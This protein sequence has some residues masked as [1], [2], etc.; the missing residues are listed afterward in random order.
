MNPFSERLVRPWEECGCHG[1]VSLLWLMKHFELPRLVAIHKKIE[2]TTEALRGEG[3]AYE[4]AK[5]IA[6]DRLIALLT[7]I[8]EFCLGVEFRHAYQKAHAALVKIQKRPEAITGIEIATILL[9]LQDDLNIAMFDHVYVQ[10]ENR[11]R[12]Y[13]EPQLLFGEAVINAFPKAAPDIQD[14]GLSIAVDLGS[15]AVFHLMHVVEWGLRGLA[16]HLG[17]SKVVINGK[18]KKTVPV[19]YS[20]WEKIIAQ[21]NEKIEEKINKMARGEKKQKAQEFYYPAMAEFRGFKDAWRNHIMHTRGVYTR[22]D[23]IAV[24]SHVERFM[25]GLALHGIKQ[26]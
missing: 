17:L 21:M 9:S 11:V 6:S 2:I 4:T 1:V 14:A 3:F 20:E 12:L 15:A 10:I 7:E 8:R 24:W 19:A 22:E 18:T 23:A 16:A 26:V 13:L 25:K 5:S